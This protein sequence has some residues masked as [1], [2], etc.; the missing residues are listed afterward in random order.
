[1]ETECETSRETI[2]TAAET[3]ET[4]VVIAPM[5]PL[6]SEGGETEGRGLRE[7]E[8]LLLIGT[9]PLVASTL[10]CQLT[11]LTCEFP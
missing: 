7:G 8:E 11:A 5:L 9:P 1:M 3:V 2:E 10:V 6:A 4:E